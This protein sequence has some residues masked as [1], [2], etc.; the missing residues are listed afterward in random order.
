VEAVK[1][2]RKA[3]EQGYAAAQHNLGVMYYNGTG[4]IKNPAQAHAW[5]SIAGSRGFKE[6]KKNLVSL[7]KEMTAEQKAEATK[8]ARELFARLRKK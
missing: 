6:A 4:V 2:C 5:W 3:A 8:L 7:E 1:W